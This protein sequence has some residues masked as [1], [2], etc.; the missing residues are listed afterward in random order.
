[1]VVEAVVEVSASSQ[2]TIVPFK[3]LLTELTTS[4][5]VRGELPSA[6]VLMKVNVVEFTVVS[7]SCVC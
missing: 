7:D 1:M 6:E 2:C 4:V 5:E 3:A